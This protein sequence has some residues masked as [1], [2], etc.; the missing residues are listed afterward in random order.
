MNGDGGHATIG[1]PE[2]LVRTTLADLSKAEVLQDGHHLARLEDWWLRH[3]SGD[4]SLNAD[5]FGFELRFAILEK[6][7][8]DFLQVAVELVKRLRLAVGA[9]EARDISDVQTGVGIAFDDCGISLHGLVR[10]LTGTSSC[11]R[12][13]GS[14]LSCGGRAEH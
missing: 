8:D 11:Q 3:W 6:E 14:R 12:P 7:S 13:N 2:L 9:R 1:M 10:I 4:D 5:E